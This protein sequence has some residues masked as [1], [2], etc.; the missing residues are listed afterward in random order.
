MHA[1]SELLNTKVCLNWVFKKFYSHQ[2]ANVV[3]K[4][5]NKSAIDLIRCVTMFS[6]FRPVQKYKTSDQGH[7]LEY[8]FFVQ[9]LCMR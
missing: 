8:H 2:N 6:H 7:S 9:R 1:E 5:G 3:T 4:L